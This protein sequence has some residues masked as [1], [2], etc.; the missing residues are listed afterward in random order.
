MIEKIA[1]NTSA[2]TF[3]N[4]VL[5]LETSGEDLTRSTTIFYNLTGSNTNPTL[6]KIEE[7]YAPIFSVSSFSSESEQEEA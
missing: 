3:A 4:T 5:A 6:Q 1:N 2:P 7:D